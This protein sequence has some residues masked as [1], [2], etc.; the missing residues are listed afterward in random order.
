[1]HQY[2]S[3]ISLQKVFTKEMKAV[4]SK[5]ELTERGA[6]QAFTVS[7]YLFRCDIERIPQRRCKPYLAVRVGLRKRSDRLA[8]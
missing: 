7:Q 5:Y 8:A 2:F 6:C 4:Y 3:Y 1:M